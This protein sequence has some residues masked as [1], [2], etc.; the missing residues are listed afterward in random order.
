MFN[1]NILSNNNTERKR[2]T[3]TSFFLTLIITIFSIVIIISSFNS[4]IYIQYI[5]TMALYVFAFFLIL[6]WKR[7]G[8]YISLIVAIFSII[9]ESTFS[10]SIFHLSLIVILFSVLQIRKNGKSTWDQMK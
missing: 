6:F 4:K 9:I 7:I 5:I 10:N 2:H 3:L 8:F 1:K